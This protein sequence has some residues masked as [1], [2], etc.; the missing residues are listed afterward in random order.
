MA[1]LLSN[2]SV[3][4]GDL[5]L[6][7]FISWFSPSTSPCSFKSIYCFPLNIV[8]Q[9]IAQKFLDPELFIHSF[10]LKKQNKTK[11]QI[12]FLSLLR[13]P[14]PTY[15]PT[16]Q[17]MCPSYLTFVMSMDN[18]P[19]KTSMVTLVFKLL[20]LFFNSW[21]FKCILAHQK[22]HKALYLSC[23]MHSFIP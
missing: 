14:V 3:S 4:M 13:V 11:N 20:I 19:V 9:T 5:R 10:F 6:Y 15:I 21:T 8:F 16:F 1:A 12:F 22:V 23:F 17:S 7:T 2:Q 18:F